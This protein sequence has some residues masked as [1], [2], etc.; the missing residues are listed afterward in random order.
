[1]KTLNI[2]SIEDF[3]EISEGWERDEILE[4][5][6]LL[7]NKLKEYHNLRRGDFGYDQFKPYNESIGL[8]IDQLRT[9]IFRA[10]SN[11]Y[12]KPYSE[13]WEQYVVNRRILRRF[14]PDFE[15][16]SWEARHE[17]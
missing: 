7:K 3:I 9:F 5:S 15:C 4:K 12:E 8:L 1:M 2:L 14:F 6:I 17:N 11:I 10:R 13:T 16:P